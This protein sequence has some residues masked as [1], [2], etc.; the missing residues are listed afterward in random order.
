MSMTEE[1]RARPILR[2]KIP[3]APRPVAPQPPAREPAVAPAP[4]VIWRCKPCGAEVVLPDTAEE[5]DIVRC[6]N[7]NANLGKAVHFLS[8][9][10]ETSRLRARRGS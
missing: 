8:D 5:G 9:P 6:R 2:L 1:P 3:P 7:C 10:P 4:K